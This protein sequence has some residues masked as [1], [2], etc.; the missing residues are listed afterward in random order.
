[1]FTLSDGHLVA[2]GASGS[3]DRWTSG[4]G[5][6]TAPVVSG[7]TV[8]VG[9]GN[10][11]VFGVSATTGK[12]VWSGKAGSV[13]LPPDEQNADVLVGMAAANGLLVVPA[14]RSLTAFAG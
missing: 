4:T 5:L 8:F 12:Q 11:T 13:I 14:G 10:G 6:V 3:P 9:S 7:G 1:M 2:V